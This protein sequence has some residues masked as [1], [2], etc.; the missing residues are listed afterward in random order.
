[1]MLRCDGGSCYDVMYGDIDYEVDDAMS[2]YGVMDGVKM[3]W[4]VMGLIVSWLV[5][6]MWR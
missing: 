4:M 1:M 6:V 3:S 2:C 5:V